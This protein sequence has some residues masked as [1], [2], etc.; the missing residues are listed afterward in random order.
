MVFAGLGLPAP[1]L[2]AEIRDSGGRLVGRV[3][4][5]FRER[6]LIVEFDGKVKYEGADGNALFREKCREDSLRSQGYQVVRLTWRDLHDPA[7]IERLIKEA[8][9]RT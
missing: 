1:E 8:F 7:R 6:R 2:Q 9:A 3:D 5:L 4:F